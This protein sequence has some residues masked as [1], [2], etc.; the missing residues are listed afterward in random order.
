M[1]TVNNS[2]RRKKRSASSLD[3]QQK[4]S[5][6]DATT[7]EAF[8]TAANA[9]S[10]LYSHS[11]KRLEEERKLGAR[12]ALQRLEASL[13]TSSVE[14]SSIPTNELRRYIAEELHKIDM[15]RYQNE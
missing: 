1:D 10:H 4:E 6:V 3:S 7:Y 5:P 13:P 11:M 15:D 9:I 8:V 2:N 14:G 12:N